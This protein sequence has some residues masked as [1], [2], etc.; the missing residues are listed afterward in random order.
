VC[1]DAS[2]AGQDLLSL[3]LGFLAVDVERL[4][5]AKRR[6]AGLRFL[7]SI[8]CHRFSVG[9]VWFLLAAGLNPVYHRFSSVW[10]R[11]LNHLSAQQLV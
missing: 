8:D 2:P 3:S 11:L 6:V 10:I 7:G 5:R 4:R 1:A 9:S